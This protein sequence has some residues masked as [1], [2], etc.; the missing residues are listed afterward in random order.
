MTGRN[1]PRMGRVSR[2]DWVEVVI[3]TRLDELARVA[4]ALDELAARC[5]LPVDAVADMQIALDE[6]VANAVTHGAPAQGD[7][8]VR[9]VIAVQ[10]GA[11]EAEVSDDG[12][13]FDPLTAAPPDR[14]SPLEQRRVGGLG[15]HFV[16]SLMSDVSYRRVG[17]RNVLLLR[18][19]LAGPGA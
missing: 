17:G 5:G 8:E 4:A 1:K 10:P 7:G 13:A 12:V 19:Q 16:R 2:Q 3:A 9:V 18:R 6:V 15:I 14:D 11:L